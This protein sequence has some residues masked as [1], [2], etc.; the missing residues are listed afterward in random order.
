MQPHSY[1]HAFGRALLALLALAAILAVGQPVHATITTIIY[2]VPGGA[3]AQTGADWANA[4]DLA[5]A[6]SG[7]SS[8][9]QIWVKRG[10]YTPT[11]DNDRSKSFTLK[12]GVAIYG[13][14]AGTENQLS[15]RNWGTNIT[16][17]S[18]D[19]GTANNNSD[20]SYHVVVGSGTD[21]TAILDGFTITGGNA[22]GAYP[23]E[24]GGG[25]YI[26]AGSPTLTNVAIIG[27]AADYGGGVYNDTSGPPNFTTGSPTLTNVV[28]SGNLAR[29]T[30]GGALLTEGGTPT[31][32]N[33]T[34]SGNS[35]THL[36]SGSGIG[37]GIYVSSGS[38][39]IRNSILWGD[40]TSS[41]VELACDS[42]PC[43]TISY[44]IVQGSGGSGS[45]WWHPFGDSTLRGT[46]GGGNLDADPKFI[47][48]INLSQTPAP[49]TAGN[50]RLGFNSA[51]FNTGSNALVPSGLTADLDDNPRIVYT[52]VDMGAYERQDNTAPSVSIDSPKPANPTNSTSAT[53]YF[54][55]SDN[56]TPSN[57]LTYQCKL[58][59]G[60]W[61]SCTSPKSY[62]NL[63]DG[64]HTFS[65]TA[66]DNAGNTSQPATYTWTVDTTAPPA[67]V[68]TSPANGSLTN[69]SKPPVGGTAE[70][71]STV[72]VY[73]DGSSRGTTPVDG[74]GNWS[75]TPTSALADGLHTVKA[76]A[77]DA[78]GNTSVDSNTNTFTVDTVAPSVSI[79]SPTPANPTNSTSATFNFSA[80]DGN[81]TG[82]ASY[83]CQLDSLSSAN[84]TSP[85]SY[86]NLSDGSHTFYV[87]AT[88]NAGNTSDPAQY[89]WTVDTTPPTA[90]P[91]VTA[92]TL[93]SNGWYTSDVTVTWN[94]SDSGSG[95][96]TATCPISST[97]SGQG[98]SVSVSATCSDLAG[99]TGS[100]S[101][102]FKIDKTAPTITITSPA[103]GAVY[104]QGAP[105]TASYTCSDPGGSGLASCVG[106]A[107]NGS[108]LSTAVPG[109]YSFTVTAT[110]NAGNSNTVQVNYTV[111][112]AVSTVSPTV[113]PP[114]VNALY[115]LSIGT[116]ATPVK[117]V[118]KNASGQA[119]TAAGTVTGI[120][121]KLNSSSA[122]C[123]SFTT[124]ATGATAASVTS[125]NP[126]YDTLQKLWVY[127]WVL[128]GRGCY[129]L[130]IT[131]N[132]TQ[133][134]PLFYHIY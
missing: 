114:S 134:V 89:R 15:Q 85:Q 75:F 108:S 43:A 12:S 66:T 27:N 76:R 11:T 115:P 93:G 104:P 99:N 50:L 26:V 118:L 90:N 52:T 58:D 41:D 71:N 129:T 72:T 109:G 95:L 125:A 5:P 120:S 6:L 44:S 49:T 112:Y 3:G 22:T 53:L 62:S 123:N 82:V 46:D 124:D 20:N 1:T 78:A 79:D 105:L 38:V 73:I 21:S 88:D 86:S 102:T 107:A 7:A 106:T 83:Q 13:G 98:G 96:N 91:V 42:F 67:P 54:S 24:R 81:G 39:T 51:A 131:L 111:G 10:T 61:E 28:F 69:K 18:G 31:L 133:V 35:V 74:S 80:S 119:I 17:L 64:S 19:I 59:N 29:G 126:K 94:W 97:T 55:G 113:G 9:A 110:D 14:F 100:S 57:Q 2:V 40:S 23:G 65:V 33:V 8:G 127:N 101:M 122:S 117:W 47:T 77:T 121:Y 30:S 4:K 63:S 128:P 25:M 32:N 34:F 45:S 103:D 84:C 36:S 16:T 68:V 60:G 130:F 70:G 56:M 87:T 48:P 132:T 37:A 92:G 116:A